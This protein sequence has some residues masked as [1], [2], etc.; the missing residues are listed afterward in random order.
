V[1]ES[2]CSFPGAGQRRAALVG[3]LLL[4][5]ARDHQHL[6]CRIVSPRCVIEL[7]RDPAMSSCV[8]GCSLAAGFCWGSKML[9]QPKGMAC[10]CCTPTDSARGAIPQNGHHHH[11]QHTSM[12]RVRVC[13]NGTAPHPGGTRRSGVWRLPRSLSAAR[14][15]L[16]P[17]LLLLLHTTVKTRPLL[18]A[19][20]LSAVECTGGDG[21]FFCQPGGRAALPCTASAPGCVHP[22]PPVCSCFG[23]PASRSPSQHQLSAV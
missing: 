13:S 15:L 2:C 1:L 11:L 10:W 19:V 9:G 17:L 5:D 21:R 22:S 3:C 16:L 6:L 20:P 4:M 12:L 18:V 14:L 8:C 23:A 7:V